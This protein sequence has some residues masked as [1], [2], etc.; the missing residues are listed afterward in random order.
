MKNLAILAANGKV[1]R[2]LVKEALLQGVKCVKAF[3]RN[4]FDHLWLK[5]AL[6]N[7]GLETSIIEDKLQA[8]H[9]IKKDIFSLSIE[10]LND[11]THIIDAFGEWEHLAL[12]KKHIMHL[13]EI[14]RPTQAKLFVVGGAGSLYVEGKTKLVD[15]PNFPAQYK[16]LALAQGEVLEYLYT[17][18]SPSWCF[19]SPAA[20]FVPDLEKAN[21]V[22]VGGDELRLNSKNQ[23]ILGYADYAAKLISL[24]IMNAPYHNERISLL[25]EY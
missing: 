5:D 21:Q 13:V 2:L 7:E 20:E 1:G 10:D 18:H 17:I 4:D 3:V 9:I 23:S 19:V 22:S 6:K 16:P 24:I 15:T 25:G 12:H 14:L 8:L 11:F